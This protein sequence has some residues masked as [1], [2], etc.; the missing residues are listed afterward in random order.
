[1]LGAES[2]SGDGFAPLEKAIWLLPS[3]PFWDQ[4]QSLQPFSNSGY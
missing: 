4:M 2:R 3:C 1:M